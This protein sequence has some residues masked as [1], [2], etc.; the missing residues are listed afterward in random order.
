M[1]SVSAVSNVLTTGPLTIPAM[2]REGYSSRTAVAVE[3]VASTGGSV[4]PQIIGTAAFLMASFAGVGYEEV[5]V[6]AAIPAGVFFL[7]LFVHIDAHAATVGM[8]GAD[9][10]TLPRLR[11][12]LRT[13]WPY[14]A[15]LGLLRALLFTDLSEARIPFLVAAALLILAAYR[16]R[17]HLPRVLLDPGDHHRAVHRR[18]G[19]RR[20]RPRR[21]VG[22]GCRA[23]AGE[24]PDGD[25]RGQRPPPAGRR[26]GDL[27]PARNGADVSAAY[28]LLAIVL[29]PGLLSLGVGLFAAHLFI[30]YW[31]SAS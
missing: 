22:H 30:I 7:G 24:R 4:T 31:A 13:G 26:R 28:V 17:L 10:A 25:R 19:G 21:A 8:R 23:L 16:R 11:S 20:P 5:L 18:H 15:A 9:P 29:V 14:L 12:V 2:I 1:V 6:A 3:A 27:L